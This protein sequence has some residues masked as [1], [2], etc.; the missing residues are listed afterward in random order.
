MGEE[1][2]KHAKKK[3][4]KHEKKERRVKKQNKNIDIKKGKERKI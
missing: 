2:L 1:I 4:N 3:K